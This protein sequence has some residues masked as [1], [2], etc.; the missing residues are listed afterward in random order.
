MKPIGVFHEILQGGFV[1]GYIDTTPATVQGISSSIKDCNI[2]ADI[3]KKILTGTPGKLHCNSTTYR[4]LLL[5]SS[6][7]LVM[8]NFATGYLSYLSLRTNLNGLKLSKGTSCLWHLST[9][10]I[11]S[12]PVHS[13]GPHFISVTLPPNGNFVWL[14]RFVASYLVGKKI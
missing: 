13:L 1:L 11:F 12:H 3:L 5:L 10:I 8:D 9:I 6:G 14:H 2:W 7:R 4:I